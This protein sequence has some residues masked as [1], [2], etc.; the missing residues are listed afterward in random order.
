LPLGVSVPMLSDKALDAPGDKDDNPKNPINKL[1]LCVNAIRQSTK[2]LQELKELCDLTGEKY[3]ALAND[4]P[5]R[6]SSTFVMIDKAIGQKKAMTMLMTKSDARHVHEALDTNDWAILEAIL[7]NLA[8]FAKATEVLSLQNYAS[9]H[10][11]G[12][13]Y[14]GIIKF[15]GRGPH[16]TN[17]IMITKLESYFEKLPEEHWL[18]EILD[19]T[20]KLDKKD[21]R[22]TQKLELL[23]ANAEAYIN[24]RSQTS[25]LAI[26]QTLPLT[27][28]R[29][30]KTTIE[31][32]DELI[33]EPVADLSISGEELNKE[34]EHYIVGP[35]A[36]AKVDPCC[37]WKANEG[38]YPTLAMIARDWLAVPAS[39]VPCEQ[40]FSLA[41][42]TVTKN[43]NCLAPETAQALLCL[44]S[45]WSFSGD[46]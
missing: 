26:I 44:R 43:R 46:F 3:H 37:W 28:G 5:T 10:N 2:L 42:N 19:P 25:Q 23:R 22:A 15:L 41:G 24:T 21:V 29:Q 33:Q 18:A 16:D 34:I 27:P 7:P 8:V 6:W 40:L 31:E 17:K 14:S 20:Q 39:S 45:W 38:E 4:C 11:V 36:G 35:K 9:M 13:I 1:R 30:K 12:H 32:F